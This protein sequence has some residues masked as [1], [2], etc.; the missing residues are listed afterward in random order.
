MK[1]RNNTAEFSGIVKTAPV[2]GHN[3]YKEDFYHFD[4]MIPRLSGVS[5][6]LPV[7]LSGKL[8][9][10]EN[11]KPGDTV[12][13]LGQ[14]RS[15]NKIV[16]MKNR[17]DIR[18]F[19]LEIEKIPEKDFINEVMIE[20]YLCK[21]PVY[22]ITPFGREIAD[23]LI[24]VNRSFGKSDYIPAI[25]WG[26]NARFVSN[27]EVGQKLYLMGRLQSRL[28]EK[29]LENGLVENRVAYELSAAFVERIEK[30]DE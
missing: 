28:Y 1:N 6:V 20:G 16:E 8:I 27:A 24:A 18:I 13:I 3:I 21:A 19:A 11:L 17:L 10:T 9:D 30:E 2:L 22:R 14:V 5:D 29:K 26:R 15:Y 7:T 4:L 12:H 23:M 25:A